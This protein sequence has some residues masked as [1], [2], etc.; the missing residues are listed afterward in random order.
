MIADFFNEVP[1]NLWATIDNQPL[2][3]LY[4]AQ[5]VSDYDQSTFDY[6]ASRF[7]ADFGA[8]PYFVREITW[9]GVSTPGVYPWGVA[10]N[11]PVVLGS[12]GTLGP[13]YDESAVYGRD[14]PRRR[15]RECGY[16]YADSWE[17]IA[18]SGARLVSVET[19]NELHEA[20]DI[21]ASREYSRTYITL[22]AEWINRWKDTDCSNAPLVWLDLGRFSYAHGLRL[23]FNYPDGAW[24]T[25]RQAGRQ[26]AYADLTTDPVSYYIYLEVIDDFLHAATSEVWVT[27][28][29][30][31][32]GADYWLLEYDS[33]SQPYKASAVI[34]LTNSGTWKQYTFHL[35]DA[36]FAGRQN[37][38]AD[39]RLSNLAWVDDTTNYF[40]RVWV[41]LSQPANLVTDLL[42]PSDVLA[43]SGGLL[44]IPLQASDPDGPPPV[45]AIENGP[46][47]VSLRT[48]G[49]ATYLRL[50][51]T[52]LDDQS[53][54]YRV[55]L[56]AQDATDANLAD[57]ATLAVTLVEEWLFLPMICRR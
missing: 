21:D 2:V 40:G 23:A 57:A 25:T 19:W 11:G 41:S 12:L 49:G 51:P 45:I 28:E 24:L 20:T 17:Q 52:L 6:A 5:Y 22:S 4:T 48:E 50:A 18:N 35:S 3:W 15:D 27:V 47:F 1:S 38:G 37:N 42:D 13:G 10:L 34:N 31:D 26:A 44:E 56:I 36:Y 16:F 7:L 53:C 46:S 55:R 30:F 43:P 8:Q 29:Y 14:D 9:E 32:G 39:L 33:V 54:L